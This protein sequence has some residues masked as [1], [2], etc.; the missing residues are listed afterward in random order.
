MFAQVIRSQRMGAPLK[1][2]EIETVEVPR[3]ATG[4]V[5]IA[6]MAAGVNFNNV[7][8][9]RGVPIDEIAARKARVLSTIFMW[10]AATRRHRVRRWARR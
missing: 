7:W 9:A 4:E 10:V 1:A 2:F 8:A 6:V 5:L 3:P